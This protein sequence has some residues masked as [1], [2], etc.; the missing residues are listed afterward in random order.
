MDARFLIHNS[1]LEGLDQFL[2]HD[3]Q[4]RRLKHLPYVYHSDLL[5]EFPMTT[6]GIYTLT[7]GRQVG[8]TTLLKQWMVKL[9]ESGVS[10][11]DIVFFTG[12][13]IDDQHVLI[14]LLQDFFN[15]TA[16]NQLKFVLID[17][18][19][20][21]SAWE[22]AIK[23]LADAGLF[24]NVVV[25]LTGSDAVLIQE[26]RMT[27]PGRRGSASKVNFHLH[28]LSFRE[29]VIL[30]KK[31]NDI[32]QLMSEELY[33]LFNLYLQHGGYLTA[34]ND[35]AQNGFI[36][37]STL[38]T[39]SD[40]IRGDCFKRGKQEKYLK[41]II[42]AIIKHY[43]SQVSWNALA[44]SLSIDHPMT[45][46]DYIELLASMDAAF[47]QHALMEDKLVGAPKKAKK[48]MFN[49]PFI[50]HAMRHWVNPVTDPYKDQILPLLNDPAAIAKV[51]EAVFVTHY[52]RYYP[53][54]YIKAEG[55][56]DIAYIREEKFWP[57]ELKWT[58][59]LRAKDLKQIG[60]YKNGLILTKQFTEG[61]I[62]GV[63][64]VPALIQLLQLGLM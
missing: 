26:A 39:Y 7:G 42:N 33:A 8:K 24:S 16:D 20:Y 59:Q 3:P 46:S 28:P 9:I 61:Q 53:T 22:K 14:R 13:I 54:Y 34:I 31:T 12:E 30:E 4:I 45:V 25:M 38:I 64:A 11:R 32:N 6:P 60:K 10:P 52:Q 62:N 21:I 58:S 17:E 1:H 27:F 56:V 49:D 40:W 51:I 36:T 48:I 47:I 37:P 57:V 5:G 41:E 18:V 19:T 29:F 44:S 63:Q 43:G 50:Y 15:Q 23:Y 55:E 35:L 2:A